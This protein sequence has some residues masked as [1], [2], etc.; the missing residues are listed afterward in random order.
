VLGFPA[1]WCATVDGVAVDPAS[2]WV[3]AAVAATTKAT[4]APRALRER[5]IPPDG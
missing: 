2:W 1:A 5:T 3:Q 4:S